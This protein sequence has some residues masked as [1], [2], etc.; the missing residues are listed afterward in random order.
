MKRTI[1]LLLFC[2]LSSFSMAEFWTS[3]ELYKDH[4]PTLD[5]M[6]YL[7]VI[8][9]AWKTWLNET[10]W[11]VRQGKLFEYG[12]EVNVWIEDP[13]LVESGILIKPDSS[14]VPFYLDDDEFEMEMYFYSFDELNAA[15]PDGDYTV[16]VT[17]LDTTTEDQEFAMP[18]YLETDFPE[19]V[20]GELVWENN[21]LKLNWSTVENVDD[22]EIEAEDLLKED[23]IWEDDVILAHPNTAT[24]DFDSLIR[25]G[26]YHC[27]IDIEAV[28]M[29]ADVDGV[30]ID[31]ISCM[32][33]WSFKKDIPQYEDKITKATVTAGINNLD[34]ISLTGQLTAVEADFLNSVEAVVTLSAAAMPAPLDFTFPIDAASF[35]AGKYNYARTENGSQM[36][37][38][39]DTKTHA[40]IFSAKKFDLTGMACPITVDVAV[41]GQFT[42]QII[43]D[44]TLVNGPKKDC[45]PQLMMGVEDALTVTKSVMKAGKKPD[46]DTLTVQGWFTVN[47]DFNYPADPFIVYLNAQTFTVDANLF[48]PVKNGIYTCT[49]IAAAEGGIV[50]VKLDTNKCLYTVSIKKTTFDDFTAA[51]FRLSIFGCPLT[52][53]DLTYW[54]VTQHDQLGTTWNYKVG[55]GSTNVEVLDGG[56]GTFE[57]AEDDAHREADFIYAKEM[58]NAA[59]LTT[60]TI[61]TSSE[62]LLGGSVALNFDDLETWPALLRPGQTHTANSA[63]TGTCEDGSTIVAGTASVTTSV[64]LA[65]V[66]V[67]VPAGTFNTVLYTETFTME[68]ELWN[69]G[70]QIGT[71]EIELTQ[72]NNALTDYGIV[73][74]I[75]TGDIVVHITLGPGVTITDKISDTFLLTQQ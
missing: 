14:E 73:K 68:G 15:F 53:V 31:M 37:M 22:Y 33:W 1:W 64:G 17:Y 5:E 12:V 30:T 61:N 4:L 62:A 70:E 21:I 67:R 2:V 32:N 60:F 19:L 13:A 11:A 63:M 16:R 59:R 7:K 6:D 27:E 74:R 23:E 26:K 49:N 40:F 35:K 24:E 25:K 43:L 10:A 58:D 55:K 52:S 8:K 48:K 71:V 9:P 65:S 56:A 39:Y 54:Q 69:S 75:R 34:T 38:K 57:V 44:E 20:D 3:V 47:G 29:I 18:A 45:P 66:N 36:M 51:D 41:G 42:A 50:S 28:N 46:T 72:T